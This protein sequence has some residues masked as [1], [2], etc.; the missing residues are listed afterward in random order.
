MARVTEV[1]P[2]LHRLPV[3]PYDLTN[4]Y[5]LDGVLV[6]TGGRRA[7]GRILAALAGRRVS[8]VALTHAHFDHQGGCHEICNALGVPLWC[9]AG[10]AAVVESGDAAM[11]YPDTRSYFA[12]FARR[13]TGPAHPV[14]RLLREGDD[15]GGFTVLETPGHTPGHIAFWRERDRALVLGDAVFHRNPL[16]GRPGLRE[17]YA[18]LA[19]D[20]DQAHRSLLRLAD[21]EPEIVCFGHGRPLL[22]AGQFQAFV[23]QASAVPA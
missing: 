21:L 3:A 4:V 2:G 12:R 13:M 22:D 1:A 8:A 17:P 9:G 11:L 15:V 16:N 6:D 10:D 23:E 5:L 20:H 19:T 18:F 7:A 14:D